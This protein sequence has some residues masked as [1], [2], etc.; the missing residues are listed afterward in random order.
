[1][2]LLLQCYGLQC[3][4]SPHTFFFFGPHILPHF[5]HASSRVDLLGS[6]YVRLISPGFVLVHLYYQRTGLHIP[7]LGH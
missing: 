3:H 6:E 4:N 1:M 5:S 2:L 7:I